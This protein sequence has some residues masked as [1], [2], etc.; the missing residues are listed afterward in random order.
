MLKARL[1][2][3]VSDPESS[4][5]LIWRLLSEYGFARWHRYAIAFLLMGFGA[6]ATALTAYLAGDVINQAYVSRD[7]SA[8]IWTSALIMLAF[9]LRGVANYAQSVILSRIG[10]SIVAENQR[11]LFERLQQQNLSYFGE[12]HSSE[13]LS[14][15]SAGAS[16]T[17]T[18]LS[19]VINAV[20]RDFL[21]LTAL[22][23]VMFIQD[24]VMSLAVFVVVPPI[25]FGLR[26]LVSRVKSVAMSQWRGGVE[27]L[28]TLHETVQGIRLVKSFTLED[29][30]RARFDANVASVESASNKMARVSNRTAPLIE[31]LAGLA[32]AFLMVYAGH[33]VINTGASP[34]EFFSFMAAFLLAYEP[35]KRLARLN[36]DL[37]VV[38]VSVRILFEVIDRAPTEPEDDGRPAL[39]VSIARLEFRDVAFS[40]RPAEPTIR[41]MSFLAEPGRMTALVGPSGGGKSTVLNL[42]LRF[43]EV[44]GGTITID[45]QDIASVS[46]RSLRQQISYVGQDVFL[47]RAT[48]RENIAFG[49]PGASEADIIA[50]AKAAQAHEF[51]SRFPQGYDTLVEERGAG[52]SGGERQRIAIAR[53]LV[54]D[55]PLIL[56]DEATASLDSE[57]E[58]YVQ[59]AIT[60][61]CKNRTTIVIAHRL[62]TVMHADKILVIEAGQVVDSGRHDE[63]LRKG[64]RYALFYRLQLQQQQE[65]EPLAAAG[66]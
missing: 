45:D 51:I 56:L 16:A 13:L 22:V 41:N 24:P 14:R 26:K 37:N 58:H 12:R 39:N 34:G 6:A 10:N 15:L 59:R 23:V 4:L 18:A 46:R 62:S 57:S 47:F 19:I 8:V 7:F 53:A 1:Q 11:R 44:S 65:R 21:T 61:L 49:R 54:K 48:I 43:Y 42:I 66:G 33:R 60:E 40:Y 5:G 52:L 25:V 32:I 20:G 35:A 27:T 2:A 3:L 36:L 55:A 28:E 30:M 38:L 63:L 50:A 9:S 31:T 29:Q 64:G 17:N